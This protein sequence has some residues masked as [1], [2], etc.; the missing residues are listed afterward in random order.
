MH[1]QTEVHQHMV[2]KLSE[3]Q[4]TNMSDDIV[5]MIS[6]TSCGIQEKI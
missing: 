5:S 3:N 6:I 4:F 1:S 2:G